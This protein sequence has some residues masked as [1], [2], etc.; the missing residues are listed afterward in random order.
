[1][2]EFPLPEP[3][4]S[5]ALAVMGKRIIAALLAVAVAILALKLVVGFVV[6][7]LTTVAMLVAVV[8]LAITAVW[9]Y[10]KL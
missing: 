5:S 7:L 2:P 6:G 1:M 10:N 8:A 9:A 4:T 3:R